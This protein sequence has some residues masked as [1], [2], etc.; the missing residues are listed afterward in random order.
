MLDRALQVI[1]RNALAQMRLIDDMLDMARVMSGKLRLELRPVD[2]A[3]IAFAAIDVVA[4]AASAKR[5]AVR[6]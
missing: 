6:S 4:P 1:D 5:I 3:A 2:L